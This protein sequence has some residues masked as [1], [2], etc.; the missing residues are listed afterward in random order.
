[1]SGLFGSSSDQKKHR[2]A[3]VVDN[4]FHRKLSG[5]R[6]Q[7][8][9][10]NHPDIELMKQEKRQQDQAAIATTYQMRA[11]SNSGTGMAAQSAARAKAQTQAEWLA[12][13]QAL[14]QA[15]SSR[16]AQS[17]QQAQTRAQS[18]LHLQAQQTQ[19]DVSQVPKAHATPQFQPQI[20][21]QSQSHQNIS[22]QSLPK[23]S[24]QAQTPV[25][26]TCPLILDLH[27]VTKQLEREVF[28]SRKHERPLSVLVIAFKELLPI[29][30]IHGVNA[31]E[32]CFD[33]ISDSILDV[34]DYRIDIVGCFN[35]DRFLIVLPETPGPQATY[36]AEMLRLHFE[37]N[38]FPYARNKFRLFASIGIAC[39][40]AHGHNWKELIARA[41][42]AA[43]TVMQNGGNAFQFG[44][45]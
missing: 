28:R 2:E 27:G 1:M 15:Q 35:T 38:A 18:Q 29:A 21:S 11:F 16:Q 45:A 12:Q 33:F 30:T 3:V 36:V 14:A 32:R 22:T 4:Q 40:P 5:H 23:I 39:L 31:Y 43:D 25:A 24:A 26:V 19:M 8:I 20:T 34:V 10:D 44:S 9:M 13:A 17:Q 6:N 7:Q 37:S 42:L 41:D